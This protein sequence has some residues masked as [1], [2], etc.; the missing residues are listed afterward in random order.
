MKLL[1]L[2][3]RP[4]SPPRAIDTQPL[5]QGDI[6]GVELECGLD[7]ELLATG[8]SRLG[9]PLPTQHQLDVEAGAAGLFPQDS[10]HR[11]EFDEFANTTFEVLDGLVRFRFRQCHSR[12]YSNRSC[13]C[14]TS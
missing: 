8:Q 2:L 7:L 6:V 3:A 1:G 5:E 14:Q 4:W 13:R 9:R 10:H 12:D 11:V